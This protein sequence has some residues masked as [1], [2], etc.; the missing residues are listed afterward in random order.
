[1]KTKKVPKSV[2]ILTA[3]LVILV[4]LPFILPNK[5][6]EALKALETNVIEP[7]LNTIFNKNYEIVSINVDRY[8]DTEDTR[9]YEVILNEE[10]SLG[11]NADYTHLNS[12]YLLVIKDNKEVVS[13]T[14]R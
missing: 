2:F 3:I 8:Q 6:L 13:F 14:R 5:S 11:H 9:T 1:M 7:H 4:L 12:S 10:F